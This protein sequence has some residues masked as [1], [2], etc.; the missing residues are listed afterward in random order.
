MTH[1]VDLQ[2]ASEH[3]FIPS[4]G[5][6]ELWVDT[7]LNAMKM[8]N[9]EVTIRVVDEVESQNL[10]LTYRNKNKPTNVLSFTYEAPEQVSLPL[11]GDLVICAPVV[12]SEATEQQ[13]ERDHHWAHL[14]IHGLLHLLGYDH[15]TEEQANEMES[16]E[17]QILSELKIDDPYQN[18]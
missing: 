4:L 5:Q 17:V 6:F 10:N 8:A 1:T 14:V 15:I 18:I 3:G 9:K 12:F 16:L 2:L 13:K 11:L 7:A